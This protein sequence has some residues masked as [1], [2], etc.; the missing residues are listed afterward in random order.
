LLE[1]RLHL[2]HAKDTV[3]IAIEVDKGF[4]EL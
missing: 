3:V 1:R 2:V 4:P